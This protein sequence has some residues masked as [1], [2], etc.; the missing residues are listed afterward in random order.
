M[1]A[2]MTLG[3]N[4]CAHAPLPH[5]NALHCCADTDNTP[6]FHSCSH[7][8]IPLIKAIHQKRVSRKLVTHPLWSALLTVHSGTCQ[9]Y[10]LAITVLL[11]SD[12]SP[13]LC[14]PGTF[15]VE[16]F[17]GDLRGHG[18]RYGVLARSIHLSGLWITTQLLPP[19]AVPDAEAFPGGNWSSAPMHAGSSW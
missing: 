4:Q 11:T 2:E 8:H 18:V 3:I 12:I 6:T 1:A 10:K 14:R 7:H 9:V 13:V 17:G 19:M 16:W 5:A 15:G